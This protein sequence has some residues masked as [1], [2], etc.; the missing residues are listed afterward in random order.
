M[1][2]LAF[3]AGSETFDCAGSKIYERPKSFLQ[4]IKYLSIKQTDMFLCTTKCIATPSSLRLFNE[5]GYQ[6]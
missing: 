6:I 3:L 1:G 4:K 5:G 2:F